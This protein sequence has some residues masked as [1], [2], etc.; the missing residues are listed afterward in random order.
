MMTLTHELLRRASPES[1]GWHCDRKIGEMVDL[2]RRIKD[3][4]LPSLLL[5]TLRDNP[6]PKNVM[7]LAA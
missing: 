2:R 6:V 4:E 7:E 1:C 3:D 5:G